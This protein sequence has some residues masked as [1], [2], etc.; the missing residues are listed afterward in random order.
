MNGLTGPFFCAHIHQRKETNVKTIMFI[1]TAMMLL[2]TPKAQ[3]LFGHVAEER[4]RRIA[5]E[6]ALEEQQR[7]TVE[8]QQLTLEQ[9]HIN[10]QQ[11]HLTTRWQTISFITGIG[12]VVMLITGT[13]IGSKTRR[14]A[15]P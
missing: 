10:I 8:A 6:H 9:Q 15:H 7:L 12:C 1:I 2:S 5:V 13:A 11:Q 3:A 4:K 14:D